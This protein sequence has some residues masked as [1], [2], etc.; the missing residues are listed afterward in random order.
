MGV[1]S[2]P[3]TVTRQRRDCHLNPDPSAPESSK[4]TTRLPSHPKSLP[5]AAH[6]RRSISAA[7]RAR[8]SKPAAHRGCAAKWD[9]QTDRQTDRERDGQSDGQT[10]TVLLRRRRRILAE[11]IIFPRIGGQ[12][13]FFPRAKDELPPSSFILS[14]PF[15]SSFLPSS[16]SFRCKLTHWGLGQSSS[17]Q[18]IWCIFESKRAALVAVV[19]VDSPN[20]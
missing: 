12:F 16:P 9:R 10:D 11:L 8:S 1:N 5:L 6:R 20:N 13:S 4:L 15:P 2:F 7:R 14:P 18:T 17:R 19:F 3:K